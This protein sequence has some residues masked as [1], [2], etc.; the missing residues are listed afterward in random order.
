MVGQ[1]RSQL[2]WAVHGMLQ[3]CMQSASLGLAQTQLLFTAVTGRSNCRR[4]TFQCQ[5]LMHQIYASKG[6]PKLVALA[7]MTYAN[8]QLRK[9]STTCFGQ[10]FAQSYHVWYA[11]YESVYEACHPHSGRLAL[12]LADKHGECLSCARHSF[13]RVRTVNFNSALLLLKTLQ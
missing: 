6:L 9:L 1:L 5:Y 7:S 4:L 10:D 8:H 12:Q 11:C 2:L 13:G 3:K